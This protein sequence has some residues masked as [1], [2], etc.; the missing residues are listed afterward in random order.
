M[1]ALN[2]KMED[3]LWKYLSSHSN[4]HFTSWLLPLQHASWDPEASFCRGIL[5]TKTKNHFTLMLSLVHSDEPNV[6][7][8]PVTWN[9]KHAI[10]WVCDGIQRIST[11][12]CVNKLKQ[13]QQR[14]ILAV[15]SENEQT[16]IH[17]FKHRQ[18]EHNHAG[19]MWKTSA[20]EMPQNCVCFKLF[21][22]LSM[23]NTN[24]KFVSGF[25]LMLQFYMA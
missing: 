16:N 18:T 23:Y 8:N 25:S 2:V 10:K 7:V 20:T 6:R 5:S 3:K 11:T 9:H 22:M 13:K 14:Q 24:P 19:R 4:T 17:T 15:Q 21:Q 1:N 12:N